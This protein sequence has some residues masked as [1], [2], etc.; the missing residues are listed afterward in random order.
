MFGVQPLAELFGDFLIVEVG[1][2]EMRV[3]FDTDVGQHHE[4]GIAAVTVDCIYPKS[5][6]INAHA[7]LVRIGN[8][9][10]AA[11]DVVAVIDDDRNAGELF[12]CF[13]RDFIG[14]KRPEA[15]RH[16]FGSFSF[17]KNETAARFIGNHCADIRILHGDQPADTAAL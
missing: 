6:H 8:R 2:R 17:W 14:R 13:K 3:A 1:E 12:E 9:R 10:G 16:R 5:C 11:R 4:L 7:P 15:A